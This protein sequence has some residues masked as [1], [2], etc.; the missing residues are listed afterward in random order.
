[1]AQQ[2]LMGTSK[3]SEQDQVPQH[4][5]AH[6]HTH[7]RT[8]AHTRMHAHAHTPRA[9][10]KTQSKTRGRGACVT[11]ACVPQVYVLVAQMSGVGVWSMCH[12]CVWRKCRVRAGGGGVA[13][14]RTKHLRTR[15]GVGAG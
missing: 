5:R 6:T 1:M 4:A 10:A 13:D 2:R 9:L 12:A 3:D 14:G 11:R 8:H 7:T 15:G